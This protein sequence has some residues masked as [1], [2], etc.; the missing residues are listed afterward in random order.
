MSLGH[1][2]GSNDVDDVRLLIFRSPIDISLCNDVIVR[3][4]HKVAPYFLS[5][6]ITNTVGREKVGGRHFCVYNVVFPFYRVFI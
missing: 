4:G 2:D 3:Y 5:L 6:P 1:I